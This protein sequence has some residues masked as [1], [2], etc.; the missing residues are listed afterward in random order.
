MTGTIDRPEAVV[1]DAGGVLLLPDPAAIREL[2][3]RYDVP[4]PDDETCWRNHYRLMAELDGRMGPDDTFEAVNWVGLDRAFASYF[5]V[6]QE[7]L[8]RAGDDMREVYLGRKWAPAPGAVEALR[9]LQDGGLPLAV[10]S[11]ALGDMEDQLASH[12]ICGVDGEAVRV[13]IVV[14]SHWVGV[15]KPDPR[16]FKIAL[17][18]LGV[19]AEACVYVGD[20]VH[21]DVKGARAAG[22]RPFHVDPHGLCPGDDHPHVASLSDFATRLLGPPA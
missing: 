11:N 4:V 3:G 17:D 21:F 12:R 5:G 1:L 13:A 9:A 19:E 6:A 2:I 10:V 20:S 7:D 22:L 14:D 15:E 18:A 16:I 8:H